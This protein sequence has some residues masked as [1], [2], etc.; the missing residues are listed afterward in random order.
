MSPPHVARLRVAHLV[1]ALFGP[2]EG[3]VGGAERYA[4]ELARHMAERTPTTLVTFGR[5][6]GTRVED[7]LTI[8]MLPLDRAVRG[9]PSNPFSWRL[10]GALRDADV[11]HCHQ[12]HIVATSAAA[13]FGRVTGKRVF[14][15]D[16]GGGGWDISA[17]LPT[18]TWFHGHLHISGYSRRIAGHARRP[19]AHVIY[20]GVDTHRFRPDPAVAREGTA[21]YVGRILPHKGLHDLIAALPDGMPLEIIGHERD[22]RYLADLERR[23]AGKSVTFRHDVD[24]RELVATYRRAR[25]VVLPSVYRDLYGRITRVPELLGQTL[26]EGMAC[27]APGVATAVASL[28]EVVRDGDTGFLVPPGDHAALRA[29]LT[30]LRDDAALADRLGAAARADVLSRFTWPAVVERCLTIYHGR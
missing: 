7:D 27:G 15:S 4:W 10:F 3:V 30:R 11:I 24:D 21:V 1:P 8:R 16:L 19:D 6:P 18:T 20:G 22:P 2:E 13:A 23:A 28:P 25:C 14:V 9:Q 12:R 5:R 26:L 17:W 29:V